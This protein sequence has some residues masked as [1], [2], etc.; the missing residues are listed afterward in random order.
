MPL[1]TRVS[2]AAESSYQMLLAVSEAANRNV[3]AHQNNDPGILLNIFK[4]P[5]VNVVET[6]DQIKARLPRL[7]ANMPPAVKVDVVLDRTVMIR[8]SVHDVEFTL[9]LTIGLVVLIILLFL[10][11]FWATFIPSITVPLAL[12][13][14][15]MWLVR[16]RHRRRRARG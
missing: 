6:V 2:S 15:T 4:Q 7:T 12:L 1:E 8:A 13:F 5:G 9:V 14:L 10:R 3:A 11:N 16:R